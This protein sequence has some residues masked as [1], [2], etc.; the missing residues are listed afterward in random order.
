[1]RIAVL[2]A[3][4][5]LL[6][7]W[8]SVALAQRADADSPTQRTRMDPESPIQRGLFDLDVRIAS[9]SSLGVGMHVA[10]SPT[11]SL[12]IGVHAP[13]AGWP[14]QPARQISY[15]LWPWSRGVCGAFA[16]LS[17]EVASL[18]T[19]FELEGQVDLGYVFVAE[20]ILVGGSVGM[21][22]APSAQSTWRVAP[23]GVVSI[24]Y[25]W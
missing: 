2:L 11:H 16:A 5:V 17:I 23:H 8:A 6:H 10:I 14:A 20:S 19:S 9:E 18:A 21:R 12:G 13:I 24:G 22:A 4:V 15:R 3:V 7:A 25:A 1:M